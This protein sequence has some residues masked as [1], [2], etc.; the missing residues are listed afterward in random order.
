MNLCT[1]VQSSM[2]SPRKGQRYSHMIIKGY[3]YKIFAVSLNGLIEHLHFVVA[4]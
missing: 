3:T 1:M 2:F 4:V